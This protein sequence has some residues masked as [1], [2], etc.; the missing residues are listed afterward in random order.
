MAKLNDFVAKSYFEILRLTPAATA[1]QVDRAFKYLSGAL[2]S[3]SD[4]GSTALADLLSEAHAAL[5]DPVRGAEYRSLAAKKDN[6]K[7][8]KRR[9]ELE[10]DP[11]LERVTLAIAARKLGEASVLIEWAGKLHP[12]RPDLA[13]HR[14]VLE[15]HL[16]NDQTTA[17]KAMGEVKRAR[18]KRDT[19]ELRLYHAWFA[20]RAR[21]RATAES[22][23]AD[24]D[25]THPLYREAMDLLTR[26]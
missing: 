2:G 13:A 23:L 15:F 4:P 7:A 12:E 26:S 17:D 24:E 9:R 25:G 21:D 8:L 20:A 6:A 11:K 14:V 22:L 10:A 1:A 19:S 5:L 18:S 3:S 16:S